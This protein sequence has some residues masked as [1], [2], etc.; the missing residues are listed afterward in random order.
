MIYDSGSK[1]TTNYNVN[2]GI[3]G[4]VGTLTLFNGML[5][6]VPVTD[7]G[8]ATSTNNTVTPIVSNLESLIHYSGQ[9]V[10]VYNLVI[11]DIASGTGN[12]VASTNYVTSDGFTTGV[13]RTAYSDLPYITSA[14]PTT[15]QDIT[16]VVLLNGAVAQ[17]VPRTAADIVTAL[18]RGRESVR[19][20]IS[21]RI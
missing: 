13:L 8:V 2:D 18:G 3:T 7:P 17:L 15:V 4:I 6:L 14:I 9:L 12:F 10:K 11:S 5:E 19:Y 21:F 20:E 1:I 16:G